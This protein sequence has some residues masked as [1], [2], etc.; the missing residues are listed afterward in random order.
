MWHG[1]HSLVHS[2]AAFFFWRSITFTTCA[3]AVAC[4]TDF[5]G[6]HWTEFR[7]RSAC[8][9]MQMVRGGVFQCAT[10]ALIATATSENIIMQ[11]T[12]DEFSRRWSR[13]FDEMAKVWITNYISL[14]FRRHNSFCSRRFVKSRWKVRHSP[15]DLPDD[16]SSKHPSHLIQLQCDAHKNGF[17]CSSKAL[18]HEILR[19]NENRESNFLAFSALN[20]SLTR[21]HH[22]D[23]HRWIHFINHIIFI[24]ENCNKCIP[25]V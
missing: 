9:R 17:S 19:L 3:S 10:A 11:E 20:R 22:T 15:V 25:T 12:T 13:I 4:A 5:S 23:R 2:S 21:T 1:R 14:P 24:H 8:E 18:N 7:A 6:C 16:F